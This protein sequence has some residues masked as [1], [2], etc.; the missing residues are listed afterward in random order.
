MSPH[1]NEQADKDIL[2][3]ISKQF[4]LDQVI[5]ES[6]LTDTICKTITELTE[7]QKGKIPEEVKIA[8]SPGITT[9]G[10]QLYAQSLLADVK[11]SYQKEK[12]MRFNQQALKYKL[13][14]SEDYWDGRVG[15]P[16][17]APF[18][19]ISDLN[20]IEI[21]LFGSKAQ[22]M[23]DVFTFP[24]KEE[25]EGNGEDVPLDELLEEEEEKEKQE[26]ENKEDEGLNF[27]EDEGPEC[28]SPDDPNADPNANPGNPL[29]GDGKLDIFVGEQCDDGN[30]NSG[31]GC[32]QFCQLETNGSDNMCIDLEAVTFKKPG[33]STVPKD[34]NDPNQNPE[35][36]DDQT[37]CPPGTVPSKIPK[38]WADE[39]G[40]VKEVPQAQ[41]YPGPFIG[42]TLKQFPESERPICGPGHTP[43][44][45]TIAG[46][47]QIAKDSNGDPRCLPTAF[48][49]D[50]D[51]AR[52]FLFGKDWEDDEAAVN[53]APAVEAM[54]CV[55]VIKNN[56]P[57]SPY[58]VIEGCIDC[59][60][61]AMVD[62]LEEALTTNVTPFKNT[63]S[64]FGLSSK[65][66]PTFSFNL[67]TE[68]KPKLKLKDS[69]ITVQSLEKT[70]KDFENSR[71]S[72]LSDPPSITNNK[73][74]LEQLAEK[75]S[76][77]RAEAE[78]LTENI[79][80]YNWST[81]AISDFELG[82]RVVPL[83]NQMQQSFSSIQS[84]YESMIA[85]TAFNEKN[86]CQ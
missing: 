82:G 66:G 70:D 14:V 22:W 83:L 7:E 19:L 47:K 6:I 84:L 75:E 35:E 26:N 25:A 80:E 43:V 10:K 63:T 68:T 72:T 57:L 39:N 21:V 23:G 17:D 64:A 32:N 54:F 15:G 86:T 50:F 38:I 52:D 62:S 69:K 53:I 16:L 37:Q 49:A 56:R 74:G 60:I 31:D 2:A 1:N 61:S 77:T 42:G 12:A 81:G 58:A 40:S 51:K 36:Q 59:H 27:E 28:V 65:F 5:I 11:N 71:S 13:K 20:L 24:T 34:P 18:D 79:R 30:K 9:T 44:E 85:E 29:C 67:L 46:K 76:S 4:S 48:C 78:K 41:E 8:C 45:I 3:V 33:S 55:D 73:G